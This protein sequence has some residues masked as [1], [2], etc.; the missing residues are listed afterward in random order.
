MPQQTPKPLQLMV[1]LVNFLLRKNSIYPNNSLLLVW[2]TQKWFDF[3]ICCD[4]AGSRA[5]SSS[6]SSFFT[7]PAHDERPSFVFTF[8]GSSL[9]SQAQPN[10]SFKTAKGNPHWIIAFISLTCHWPTLFSVNKIKI[11][12]IILII[13]APETLPWCSLSLY[14]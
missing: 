13:R 11:L 8:N 1:I 12:Q 7:S 9:L 10:G 2:P 14:I 6:S 4:W 5:S 3:C